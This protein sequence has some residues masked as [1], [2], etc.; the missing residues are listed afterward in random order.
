[1]HRDRNLKHLIDAMAFLCLKFVE[2]LRDHV[3]VVLQERVRVSLQVSQASLASLNR[4][5]LV[6]RELAYLLKVE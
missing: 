4:L 3:G 5:K 2:D 1:M 6:P